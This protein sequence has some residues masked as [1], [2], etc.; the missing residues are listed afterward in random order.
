VVTS[1]QTD[2]LSQRAAVELQ[3]QFMLA[4]LQ[5]LSELF[6]VCLFTA[7]RYINYVSLA[8]QRRLD[9]KPQSI[10]DIERLIPRVASLTVDCRGVNISLTKKICK[11]SNDK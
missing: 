2:T 11:L 3:V 10:V 4:D 5:L 1:W 6:E 9:S 7:T 8:T